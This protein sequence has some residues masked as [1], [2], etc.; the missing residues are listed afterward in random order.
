MYIDNTRMPRK[1]LL[2]LHYAVGEIFDIHIN[3]RVV[4]QRSHV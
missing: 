4:S 2:C 1:Y 3:L